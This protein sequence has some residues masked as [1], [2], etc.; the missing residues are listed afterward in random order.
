N[1]YY[2]R[3][4][5][6]SPDDVISGLTFGFW[7][8]IFKN[9]GS[10]GVNYQRIISDVF[11]HSPFYKQSVSQ[12]LDFKVDSRMSMIHTFRNRISHHEPVWKLKDMMEEKVT[13]I[14]GNKNNVNV[15]KPKP[16][17]KKEVYE[18]LE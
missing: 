17:N 13:P 10:A 14:P 11:V 15:L 7:R 3:P 18:H 12:S 9:L 4:H 8:L 1:K 16:L 6:I 2:V 5:A